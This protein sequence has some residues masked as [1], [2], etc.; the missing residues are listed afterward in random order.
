ML[1]L[2]AHSSGI[3]D[4]HPASHHAHTPGGDALESVSP[5]T[6][7]EEWPIS[8]PLRAAVAK[9]ALGHQRPIDLSPTGHPLAP[10][11]VPADAAG[12]LLQPTVSG[13]GGRS[14][15]L[16]PSGPAAE[17]VVGSGGG[18][19]GSGGGMGNEVSSLGPTL[20]RDA[21]RANKETGNVAEDA[22]GLP[23]LPIDADG[24][25]QRLCGLLDKVSNQ[26]DWR[27]GGDESVQGADAGQI[28]ALALLT[29]RSCMSASVGLARCLRAQESA[30]RWN[31]PSLL[32]VL[33]P[34]P[35]CS[36]GS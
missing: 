8:A 4:S 2:L 3:I 13:G 32:P 6:A 12:G 10:T 7:A 1:R 31:P 20:S 5:R 28:L 29:V 18:M 35:L 19:P 26:Q 27:D 25:L 30:F 14:T 34:L 23:L 9:I 36:P 16:G 11:G 33:L 24:L 17:G 21:S 22:I 15:H